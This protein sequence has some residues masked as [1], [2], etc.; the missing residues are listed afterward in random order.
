MGCN[1]SEPKKDDQLEQAAYKSNTTKS[2]S[3]KSLLKKD[4]NKSSIQSYNN[5][6]SKLLNGHTPKGSGNLTVY[7][8]GTK[9]NTE[10]R[11]INNSRLKHEKTIREILENDML[12][13]KALGLC[14]ENEELS[15]EGEDSGFITFIQKY[16]K[17]SI[18]DQL[19]IKC[20]VTDDEITDLTELSSMLAISII[21]Y[22]AQVTKIKNVVFDGVNVNKT[23]FQKSEV[24]PV[25]K[26]ISCWIINRYGNGNEMNRRNGSLEGY[27]DDDDDE[28]Y[29]AK[30]EYTQQM[31]QYLRDFVRFE[32]RSFRS[33]MSVDISLTNKSGDQENMESLNEE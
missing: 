19:Y 30:E 25:A 31:S 10:K 23:R 27:D 8:N 7:K 6:D 32:W 13:E 14:K 22:K 24:K 29:I 28:F 1:C 12:K 4:D 9:Q 5:S 33:M 11:V 17:Q 21:L 18:V 3:S 2:N 15:S 16:L 26:Y 20:E